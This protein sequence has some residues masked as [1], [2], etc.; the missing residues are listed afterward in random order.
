MMMYFLHEL[1]HNLTTG[2]ISKESDLY[3]EDFAKSIEA[4]YD[5]FVNKYANKVSIDKEKD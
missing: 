1:I 2:A 4:I 3:N 5:E